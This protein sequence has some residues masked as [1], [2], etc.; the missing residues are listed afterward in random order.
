VGCVGSHPYWHGRFSVGSKRAA[1]TLP[2]WPTSDLNQGSS[3]VQN[4]WLAL[5]S[6]DAGAYAFGRTMSR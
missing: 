6:N 4:W 5:L 2:R 1:G 3:S